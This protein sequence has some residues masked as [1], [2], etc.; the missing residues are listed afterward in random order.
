M[1]KPIVLSLLLAT[2]GSCMA[3]TVNTSLLPPNTDPKILAYHEWAN[4]VI[5]NLE[6]RAEYGTEGIKERVIAESAY[7]DL[8]QLELRDTT[9]YFYSVKGSSSYDFN[10]LEYSSRYNI[11]LDQSYLIFNDDYKPDVNMDSL[12]H[13]DALLGLTSP[14]RKVKVVYDAD[15]DIMDYKMDLYSTANL[16]Y[17]EH[18]I[19]TYNAQGH[20]KE[21]L[22]LRYINNQWDSINRKKFGYNAQGLLIS[23]SL[24]VYNNNDWH[25]RSRERITYNASNQATQVDKEIWVV[26]DTAWKIWASHQLSYYSDGKLKVLTTRGY[27]GTAFLPVYKDS[28]TY[29]PGSSFFLSRHIS[30][31]IFSTVLE[32]VTRYVR[33]L[34]AQQL[35][36]TAVV[37]SSNVGGSWSIDRKYL[38]T[39]NTSNNPIRKITQNGDGDNILS[40]NY[41]YEQYDDP[42]SVDAV[43]NTKSMRVYP[44]P[45]LT[46]LCMEWGNARQGQNVSIVLHNL[47]G[48]VVYSSELLWKGSVQCVNIADVHPGL[49]H[50]SVRDAKGRPLHAQR[51]LKR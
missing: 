47:T 20:L 29:A 17:G 46:E 26:A 45:A 41:Y 4:G 42:T 25:P 5:N 13:Y 24:L 6:R 8:N 7:R 14:D 28:L 18:F 44:N 15:G 33:H 37:L 11:M 1:K 23:D 38:L 48:Q 50:L 34:N 39:Y 22:L 51:I 10:S 19:N 35:P 36:D 27:V 2:A 32:P 40:E 43:V 12:V 49:Y 3:Q 16:D 9:R 31:T 21:S 30:M